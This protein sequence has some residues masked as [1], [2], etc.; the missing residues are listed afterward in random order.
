MAPPE[1]R[2]ARVPSS[3]SPK[4]L[5]RVNPKLKSKVDSIM[6]IEKTFEAGKRRCEAHLRQSFEE[7][8]SV[9]LVAFKENGFMAKL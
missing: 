1:P 6:K 3:A 8:S 7:S 9:K 4:D 5:V 2:F